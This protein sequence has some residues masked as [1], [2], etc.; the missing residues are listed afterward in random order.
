ML[1]LQEIAEPFADAVAPF[2]SAT[3]TEATPAGPRCAQGSRGC[4]LVSPC[5]DWHFPGDV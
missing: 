1:S 5:S 3:C 2:C 4:V